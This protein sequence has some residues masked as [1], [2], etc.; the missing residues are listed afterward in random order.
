MLSFINF[1]KEK[2]E[3]IP[4][5]NLQQANQEM[6]DKKLLGSGKF[7]NVFT[8]P[9]DIV[10]VIKLAKFSQNK[11]KLD[12]YFKFIDYILNEKN[13]SKILFNRFLPQITQAVIIQP[14]EK[15]PPYLQVEMEK[16]FESKSLDDKQLE[17][18]LNILLGRIVSK[19]E[20]G[21]LL[22]LKDFAHIRSEKDLY[23]E[24]FINLIED[25]K[26]VFEVPHSDFHQVLQIIKNFEKKGFNLDIHSG[27]FMFRLLP[28]GPQLVIIDPLFKI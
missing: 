3:T 9:G 14:E 24:V 1:L 21:R 22:Y 19:D 2:I 26:P 28:T 27:N 5:P 12:G 4:G 6:N 20:L 13:K 17:A 25:I 10:E 7:G 23:Y 18:A 15:Q 8:K 11:P 16:L